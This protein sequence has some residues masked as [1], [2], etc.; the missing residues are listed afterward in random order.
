MFAT[1]LRWVLLAAIG[2]GLYLVSLIIW[3]H[4]APVIIPASFAKYSVTAGYV[5]SAIIVWFGAQ[6]ILGILLSLFENR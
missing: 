6:A 4:L 1:L 2:Y 3:S 5:F